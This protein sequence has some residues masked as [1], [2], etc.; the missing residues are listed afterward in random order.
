MADECLICGAELEY[1]PQEVR[2]TCALCGKEEMTPCRCANGHYVCNECHMEGLSSFFSVCLR[3][4]SCDPVAI[5]EELMALPFC[6][7]H[8]PEHHVLAGASLLTACRNAGAEIDLPAALQQMHQRGKQVPGGICGLW[9]SCGAGISTGICV[10]ILSGATPLSAESWGLANRMTAAALEKI[11][12][13]G[14]P[15]CCKRDS[16]LA[17]LAA[18]PFLAEHFGICLQPHTPVCSRSAQNNQCLQGS[19]PFFAAGA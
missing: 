8:G 16:Y 2:M 19:C 5:L 15:R 7:M 4:T 10:S 11:G 18:V 1:L 6:H 17:L 14:G 9:G 3:S 13:V 12:S